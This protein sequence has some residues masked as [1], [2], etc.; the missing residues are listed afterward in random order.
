M[1]CDF[2]LQYLGVQHKEIECEHLICRSNR[3]RVQLTPDNSSHSGGQSREDK[4]LPANHLSYDIIVVSAKFLLWFVHRFFQMAC[5]RVYLASHQSM[6]LYNRTPALLRDKGTC[7]ERII[8][9]IGHRI[10]SCS[11]VFD[12]EKL[13]GVRISSL[14]HAWVT[15][16]VWRGLLPHCLAV[17]VPWL[18]VILEENHSI[19]L[20]T[21]RYCQRALLP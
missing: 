13:H 7:T 17:F 14:T 18:R 15:L 16:S 19:T 21:P 4:R 11:R 12:D 3:I 20:E 1:V 8:V 2:R 9:L 10:Q 6:F 5:W